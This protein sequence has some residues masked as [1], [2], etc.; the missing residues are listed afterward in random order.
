MTSPPKP[1]V[2]LVYPMFSSLYPCHHHVYVPRSRKSNPSFSYSCPLLSLCSSPAWAFNFAILSLFL[3][4]KILSV[5]FL[6]IS[7]ICAQF[8][9]RASVPSV[10][11][12]SGPRWS[13]FTPSPLTSSWGT[14]FEAVDESGRAR[15]G[16]DL[17]LDEDSSEGFCGLELAWLD[18]VE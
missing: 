5:F 10:L 2:S 9:I 18:I 8:E 6:S 16:L 15:T 11:T 17:S 4:P 12:T 1:L 7:V 14:S 13:S 3:F